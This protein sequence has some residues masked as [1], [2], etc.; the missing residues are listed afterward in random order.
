M[1]AL[2]ALRSVGLCV[3]QRQMCLNVRWDSFFFVFMQQK[4]SFHTVVVF[5]W[6]ACNKDINKQRF[7]LRCREGMSYFPEFQV[8]F[9]HFRQ[10]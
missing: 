10:W 6:L 7:N 4:I 9:L 5:F 3:G 1:K 8:F 2:L